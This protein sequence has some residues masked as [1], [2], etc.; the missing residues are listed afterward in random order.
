MKLTPD[1]LIRLQEISGME[2]PEL[3]ALRQL[4]IIYF[5]AYSEEVRIINIEIRRRKS[6]L[7]ELKL[8]VE[9]LR[10]K[11]N[12]LSKEITRISILTFE[13]K[14]TL[15][16]P[17]TLEPFTPKSIY[18]PDNVL[19]GKLAYRVAIERIRSLEQEVK[20]LETHIHTVLM[21]GKV[22]GI[23][24]DILGLYGIKPELY[25][26]ELS[27]RLKTLKGRMIPGTAETIA[28]HMWRKVA[29]T[30]E[31]DLGPKPG[32]FLSCKKS[33]NYREGSYQIV[34]GGV[35][36]NRYYLRKM[37]ENLEPDDGY[38]LFVACY[39]SGYGHYI[40][41]V[42]E[43]SCFEKALGSSFTGTKG[44]AGYYRCKREEYRFID[45][46]DSF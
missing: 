1:R 40:I 3:Q 5:G 25:R 35:G 18:D 28:P 8:A 33:K 9:C 20:Q 46:L 36:Y 4:S 45:S 15:Y 21:V 7:P 12:Q 10:R 27:V 34:M 23:T 16:D 30:P 42:P 29:P 26:V 39:L 41:S 24:M 11:A 22:S 2:L 32:N 19:T 14:S 44:Q 17:V 6:V 43:S 31:M 13:T 37:L 38:R